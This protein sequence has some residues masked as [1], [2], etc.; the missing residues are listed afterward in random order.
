MYTVTRTI[1]STTG[2]NYV[3]E[4]HK[5][6]RTRRGAVNLVNREAE[7]M[8]IPVEWFTITGEP[9]QDEHTT[10]SRDDVRV[11]DIYHVISGYS[12]TFNDYYEVVSV[13]A[14]GKSCTVMPLR[15]V[16]INGDIN[17]PY[18]CTVRPVTGVDCRFP[19]N[20]EPIRRC[21]TRERGNTITISGHHAYRMTAEEVQR[22]NHENHWD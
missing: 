6:Y 16:I 12:M 18:G 19:V 17:S 4:Y 13:S 2:K 20:A 11:G 8:R 1:P 3:H 15:R 22:G 5:Q 21:L 7:S 10:A 9:E 14:T